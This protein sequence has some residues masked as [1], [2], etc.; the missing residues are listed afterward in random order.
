MV[1]T[2]VAMRSSVCAQLAGVLG[3][4]GAG[5]EPAVGAD[6]KHRGGDMRRSRDA[7]SMRKAAQDDETAKYGTCRS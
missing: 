3:M 4:P 2:P 7:D 6:A 1:T 5:R